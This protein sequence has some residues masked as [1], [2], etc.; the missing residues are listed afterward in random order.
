MLLA[1]T[2]IQHIGATLGQ[3]YEKQLKDVGNEL[4]DNAIFL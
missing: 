3:F 4:D 2:G 1:I